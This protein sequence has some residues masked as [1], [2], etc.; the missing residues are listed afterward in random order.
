MDMDLNFFIN[1]RT[2]MYEVRAQVGAQVATAVADLHLPV[3]RAV[4]SA[5][6]SC[7]KVRGQS[8]DMR[9]RVSATY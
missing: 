2:N 5:C 1:D 4:A 9:R 7:R 6:P 3:Q 8:T